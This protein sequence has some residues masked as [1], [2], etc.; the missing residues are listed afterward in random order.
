MG[1]G[2]PVLIKIFEMNLNRPTYTHMYIHVHIY[3]GV[4]TYTQA[5]D[6]VFR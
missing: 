2:Q 4:C 1:K 3:L 6:F 5:L